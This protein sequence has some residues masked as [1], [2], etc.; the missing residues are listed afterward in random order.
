MLSWPKLGGC[1]F[2]LCITLFKSQTYVYIYIYLQYIV[3]YISV[4]FLCG[5]L[6]FT[7]QHS[8]IW[9][10]DLTVALTAR[11]SGATRHATS[12]E[13][14]CHIYQEGTRQTMSPD[15]FLSH[16]LTCRMSWVFQDDMFITNLVS[17]PLWDKPKTIMKLNK[18]E[19]SINSNPLEHQKIE[20]H[21]QVSCVWV[22]PL[23]P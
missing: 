12:F 8:A 1:V 16:Q 14:Q 17:H 22:C 15:G 7:H 20:D 9:Q 13:N 19:A 2:H 3:L 5:H 6:V 23:K 4:H 21:I 10:C 18:F 11:P